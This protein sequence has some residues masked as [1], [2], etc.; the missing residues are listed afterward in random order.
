MVAAV[1]AADIPSLTFGG[2]AMAR[3]KFNSLKCIRK[4]DVTGS[5]E[6]HIWVNGVDKWNFVM[7]KGETE[8][9]ATKQVRGGFQGRSRQGGAE[10]VESWRPEVAWNSHLYSRRPARTTNWSTTSSKWNTLREKVSGTFVLTP[11]FRGG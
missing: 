8:V 3:V 5:D 1:I 11:F 2:K 7:K 6:P 10:G 9:L 4:Q